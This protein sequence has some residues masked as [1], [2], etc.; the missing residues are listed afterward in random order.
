M[1]AGISKLHPLRYRNIRPNLTI[2]AITIELKSLY[3]NEPSNKKRQEVS[4]SLKRQLIDSY[5][6]NY[7]HVH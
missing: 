7:I 2:Y 4:G 6:I 1:R 5:E 3:W